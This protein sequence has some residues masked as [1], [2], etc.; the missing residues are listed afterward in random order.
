MLNIDANRVKIVFA[1]LAAYVFQF[2]ARFAPHVNSVKH[3]F[4]ASSIEFWPLINGRQ[5]E[6]VVEVDKASRAV[7]AAFNSEETA[8]GTA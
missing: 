8:R 3:L 7:R 6:T 4:G 2:S 5:A 1:C